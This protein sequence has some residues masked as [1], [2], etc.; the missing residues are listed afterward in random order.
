MNADPGIGMPK[1]PVVMVI[2]DSF[3]DRFIADKIIRRAGMA[4]QV[5]LHD[6]ARSALDVLGGMQQREE[7]PAVIFLDIRMPDMDGF[8]FLEAFGGLPDLVQQHTHVVMLSSSSFVDDRIRAEAHACVRGYISKPLTEN[9]L[10]A[11]CRQI[12]YRIC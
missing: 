11:H 2:D 7:V 4:E 3:P 6:S 8:D 1:L 9:S 12:G 5:L 10:V